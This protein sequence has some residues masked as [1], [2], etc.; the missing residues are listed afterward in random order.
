MSKIE[1]NLDIWKEISEASA[2]SGYEKRL[3]PLLKKWMQPYTDEIIYDH[4]MS[5]IGVHNGNENGPTIAIASHLDEV[6]FQVKHIS[7]DGFVYMQNVGGWW[8]HV[9]PAQVFQIE[10]NKLKKVYGVIGCKPPHGMSEKEKS[11]VMNLEDLYLDLGVSSA[12]EVYDLGV[13]IGN[14]ITPNTKFME[15]NNKDYLL[16]KAWDDR[17]CMAVE[18]ELLSRIGK[19]KTDATVYFVGTAQEEVGQRGA[20]TIAHMLN[21]DIS[22]AL[23]V[24]D[25]NDTPYSKSGDI[26]LGGGVVLTLMDASS[27]AH[28]KLFS[29]VEQ[30]CIEE[31]IPFQYS[32]SKSGGTDNGNIH[33]SLKGIIGMTLSLATRY[34]H[35]SQLIIHKQDMIAMIKLLEIL[36]TKITKADIE[37]MKAYNK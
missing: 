31:K 33:K 6:G 30:I 20:R 5:I 1:L 11:T 12:K 17:C 13:E 2:I 8:A 4:L 32:C 24:C 34:M 28:A 3:H 27:I 29:Y 25:A 14:Q 10:T 23:D 15:L 36:C 35:S 26:V 21:P 37:M 19:M 16:G 7:E 9:L 18:L 22:F